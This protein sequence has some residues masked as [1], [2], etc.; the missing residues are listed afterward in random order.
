MA[1]LTAPTAGSK[2][3]SIKCQGDGYFYHDD[4]FI[5]WIRLNA[6]DAHDPT[7]PVPQIMTGAGISDCTN[8]TSGCYI[9]SSF[10]FKV[11]YRTKYLSYANVVPA[12]E[13]LRYKVTNETGDWP[14]RFR[15]TGQSGACVDTGATSAN[16]MIGTFHPNDKSA[17]TGIYAATAYSYVSGEGTVFP[18]SAILHTG[19]IIDVLRMELWLAI[20]PTIVEIAD[21]DM[22]IAERRL[23]SATLQPVIAGTTELSASLNAIVAQARSRVVALNSAI[24]DRKTRTASLSVSVAATNQVQTA[25][26][27]FLHGSEFRQALLRI[28]I[29]DEKEFGIDLDALVAETFQRSADLD[30]NV[31]DACHIVIEQD[32]PKAKALVEITDLQTGPPLH[33]NAVKSDTIDFEASGVV[34]TDVLEIEEGPNQGNYVIRGVEGGILFVEEALPSTDPGPSAAQVRRQQ[35]KTPQFKSALVIDQPMFNAGYSK[36]AVMDMLVV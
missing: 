27:V 19:Q 13:I 32:R 4:S 14:H 7:N 35:V 15:M 24:A 30:L 29:A 36:W 20:E 33:P 2:T 5:F 17:V 1:L 12:I 11:P 16:G 3:Y 34:P 31:S 10:G 25:M 9:H 26:D 18:H 23:R 21:L 6:F 22:W 28:A 8:P